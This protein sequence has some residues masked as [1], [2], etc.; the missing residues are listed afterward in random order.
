MPGF[1]NGIQ[2]SFAAFDG[3]DYCC[4]RMD[5]MA[6][7]GQK[8]FPT[9]VLVLQGASDFQKD[10]PGKD[11]F[12]V[13]EMQSPPMGYGRNEAAVKPVARG[14]NQRRSASTTERTTDDPTAPQF[15]FVGAG[16]KHTCSVSQRAARQIELLQPRAKGLDILLEEL[17]HGLPRGQPSTRQKGCHCPDRKPHLKPLGDEL[18]PGSATPQVKQK[19]QLV[20]T[21]VGSQACNPLL[22]L[23]RARSARRPFSPESPRF[24]WPLT[25]ASPV[26]RP[27]L[28]AEHLSHLHPGASGLGS[29]HHLETYLSLYRSS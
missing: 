2:P 24:A 5:G 16:N 26:N 1:L 28:G 29:A 6:A 20:G 11:V 18:C 9:A 4:R 19:L 15:E 3:V 22:L 10:R 7:E 27:P 13:P 14:Q 12:E 25:V 21:A 17:L 8:A 23:G